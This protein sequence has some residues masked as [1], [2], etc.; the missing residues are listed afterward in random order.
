MLLFR[1]KYLRN[2]SGIWKGLIRELHC[3]FS[4]YEKNALASIFK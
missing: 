2:Y 1:D 3:D 4:V